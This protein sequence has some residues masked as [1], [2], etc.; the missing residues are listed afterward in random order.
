[1]ISPFL[2]Q[3]I[4]L[5]FVLLITLLLFF[6]LNAKENQH[7]L[8]QS[9]RNTGWMLLLSLLLV[10]F[11]GTRPN[12][13]VFV[14]SLTYANIYNDVIPTMGGE[15]AMNG[16]ALFELLM[17][18]ANPIMSW[19]VFA[20]LIAVVYVMGHWLVS[21][22]LSPKNADVM[23]L[24]CISA[25]SFWG[26]ATNGLRN[27]FACVLVLVALTYL[28]QE[29]PKVLQFLLISF[30]AVGCHKSVV[31]PVACALLAYYY[32]NPKVMFY[33]W[34]FS[35]PLSFIAG[36]SVEGLLLSIGGDD[37][38]EQYFSEAS[39]N[40]YSYLFSHT[41]FRWDFLLYSFIPIL[42]G[43]YVIFK[44]R[45]IDWK[46]NLLLATYIYSNSF[47][48]MIIRASSSNRFAYLSW[49]IYPIVLSYPL[50]KLQVFKNN[51]TRNAAIILILHTLFTFVMCFSW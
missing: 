26:Y 39:K 47:W 49:F 12:H 35:I 14:D 6:S 31:L 36:S 48:V 46:Y 17:V 19:M 15:M 40:E 42:L 41:G 3:P 23:M 27:G 4:Y 7:S 1:M 45:I 20:T 25:F 34:F 18:L 38:F 33:V 9:R 16:D 50:L 2:Y 28:V 32:R 5:I 51:H 8:L 11:I 29:K 24:F 13:W 22:R 21:K 44:R 37:R 10:V 30:V 43:W